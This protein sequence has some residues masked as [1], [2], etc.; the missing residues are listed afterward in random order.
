MWISQVDKCLCIILLSSHWRDS[1]QT[2]PL[3]IN[4]CDQTSVQM[5]VLSFIRK[6][7]QWLINYIKYWMVQHVCSSLC[8]IYHVY[9]RFGKDKVN[10]ISKTKQIIIFNH[11]FAALRKHNRVIWIWYKTKKLQCYTNRPELT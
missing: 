1:D 4:S 10:W 11:C 2:G 5:L 3:C 8:C 7:C 9:G 6:W